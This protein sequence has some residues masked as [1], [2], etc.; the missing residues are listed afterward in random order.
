MRHPSVLAITALASA[1]LLGAGC[2]S[3]SNS[4]SS[5]SGGY[6][7]SSNAAAKSTPASGAPASAG[8]TTPST[9]AG[10][11]VTTAHTSLGT[12]LVAGPNHMTVY[13]FEADKGTTSNCSSACA[14]AWPPVTT[15]GEPKAEGGAQ[16]AHLG[17][18]TRSDGTKQVTYNGHPLY[19]YVSD[20]SSGETTGQGVKS[21]GAAWYVLNPAGKKIDND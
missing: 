1:G 11:A 15:S 10:T 17:T 4:S 2:G 7:S 8:A 20:Q 16:S 21:F 3:S 18:T 5:G 9:A 6:P 12:V 19:Y 13:L 14:Q